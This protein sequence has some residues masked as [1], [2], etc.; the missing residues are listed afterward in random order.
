MRVGL[1][2]TVVILALA[3][4]PIAVGAKVNA[5]S[6]N[7]GLSQYLEVVPGAGGDHP[8]TP[9]RRTVAVATVSGGGSG[10]S[11]DAGSPAADGGSTGTSSADTKRLAKL[12]EDERLLE[13]FVAY[14][15][16]QASRDKVEPGD[17]SDGWLAG[18]ATAFTGSDAGAGMGVGLPLLLLGAA[19]A[20]AFFAAGRRSGRGEG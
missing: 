12:S 2:A 5:P 9:L 11:G 16:P 1:V 8:S 10:G 7:S 4:A 19:V 3:Q 18:I 13:R 17:D 14:S 6:G 20:A 15:G